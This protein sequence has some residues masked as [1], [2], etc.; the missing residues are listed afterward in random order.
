MFIFVFHLAFAAMIVFFL[1]YTA[2]SGGVG[3]DMEM[4]C[5]ME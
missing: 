2:N 5:V 4:Y 1:L 3:L